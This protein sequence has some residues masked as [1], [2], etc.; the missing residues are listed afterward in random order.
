MVHPTI[1]CSYSLVEVFNSRSTRASVRFRSL[2]KALGRHCSLIS[3]RPASLWLYRLEFLPFL[4]PAASD[5]TMQ[6]TCFMGFLGICISV[7]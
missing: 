3:T 5:S 4:S 2:A 6:L 7:S 1:V